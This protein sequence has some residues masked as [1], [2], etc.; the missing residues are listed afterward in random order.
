MEIDFFAAVED[1]HAYGKDG[2]G[3][4]IYDKELDNIE[5]DKTNGDITEFLKSIKIKCDREG[6]WD[7]R[8]G[9]TVT[10]TLS[11]SHETAEELGLALKET[12]RTYTITELTERIRSTEELDY[13]ALYDQM[14]Q[15]IDALYEGYYRENN[16]TVESLYWVHVYDN[17]GES[18]VNG[19]VAIISFDDSEGRGYCSV[20]MPIGED[21]NSVYGEKWNSFVNGESTNDIREELEAFAQKWPEY[22]RIEKIF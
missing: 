8:N 18:Y 21:V 7:L 12:S 13:D 3:H 5:Y 14:V 11:Y 10:L 6:D 9:D 20:E 4:F 17:G 16:Y 15:T 2:S 19:M 1:A 22:F